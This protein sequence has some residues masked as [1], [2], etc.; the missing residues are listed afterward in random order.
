MAV[1]VGWMYDLQ[2]FVGDHV[3]WV[4]VCWADVFWGSCVMGVCWVDV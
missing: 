1:C 2:V 3:C 4:G